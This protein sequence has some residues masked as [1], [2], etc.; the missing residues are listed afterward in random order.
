MKIYTFFLNRDEDSKLPIL[1]KCPPPN[2]EPGGYP[3]G[4]GM[5]PPEDGAWMKPNDP[6]LPE[7][8]YILKDK[9]GK[10]VKVENDKGVKTEGKVC[11]RPHEKS[12]FFIDLEDMADWHSKTRSSVFP[13]L[14]GQKKD[15]YE[16]IIVYM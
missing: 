9:D 5:D 13:F 4:K 12:L 11:G 6:A 3:K 14:L 16:L 8:G 1:K 10:K 15:M 7:G 2:F